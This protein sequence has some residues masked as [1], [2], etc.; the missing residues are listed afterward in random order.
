MIISLIILTIICI[1]LVT[2]ILLQQGK[3]ADMGAAFGSGSSNTVFGSKGAAPFLLK[4][5]FSLIVIFFAMCIFIGYISSKANNLSIPN[6]ISKKIQ[7]NAVATQDKR[8]TPN[9]SL[10]NIVKQIN[11]QN[12][13]K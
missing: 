1:I 5:T 10:N 13:K 9:N 11:E 3:G 2:A 12:S 6:N 7:S 8:D 4:A